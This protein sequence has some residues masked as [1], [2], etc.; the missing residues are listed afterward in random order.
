MS[1]VSSTSSLTGV[2]TTEQL[3]QLDAIMA[4]QK[5]QESISGSS[6]LGK[7]QFLQILMTQLQNQDPLNP[8]EDKDFISQMAQFS[9]LEKLSSIETT[10]STMSSTLSTGNSTMTSIK[11]SI[12]SLLAQLKTMTTGIDTLSTTQKQQLSQIEAEAK[13][14][15]DAINATKAQAAYD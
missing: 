9:S 8:L 4:A 6:D 11:T 13:A 2:F 3:K 14:I 5:A 7:D 1:S 10:M 15:Q 12:D